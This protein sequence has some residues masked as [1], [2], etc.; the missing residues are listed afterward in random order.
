[1]RGD[2]KIIELLN[3]VLTAE[4]T[5]INQYF[6]HAKMCAELGLRAAGR[7]TS[8]HESID[9]MKHADRLIDRIL[10]LEGVPNLQRLDAG[11]RRRDRDRAVPVDLQ[12]EYATR[13]SA[14]TRRSQRVSLTATTPPA[15]CSRASW[16]PKKSTPT[17][18]RPSW[19]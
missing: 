14:S 18:S 15:R 4:L 13:S 9:E 12:L 11:P 1:M 6:I 16:S 19:A 3:D 10:F 7:A 5:A 2:P 17:G 8:V